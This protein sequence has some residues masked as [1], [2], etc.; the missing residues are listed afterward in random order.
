MKCALE[1][2]PAVAERLDPLNLKSE[3]SLTVILRRRQ[4]TNLGNFNFLHDSN[5]CYCWPGGGAGPKNCCAV[6]PEGLSSP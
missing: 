1:L 3:F 5:D 4:S 2:L 6:G